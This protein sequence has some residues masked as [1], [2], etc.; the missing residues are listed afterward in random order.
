MG[1]RTMKQP[2][3]WGNPSDSPAE[4]QR[5]RVP[6]SY[7]SQQARDPF[8]V[9]GPAVVSFSGGRT[10]AMMLRLIL[11]RE[12]GRLPADVHAVFSNTGRERP[13]TLDF[14][15]DCAE[16]WG[17][18]VTW[19]ERAPG[20]HGDLPYDQRFRI[21]DHA[22]ASRNGEP[23]AQLIKQRSFPPSRVMRFCTTELKIRVMR[24]FMRSRGYDY[25]TNIVGLRADETKRVVNAKAHSDRERWAI[26]CPLHTA[27]LTVHD[28]AAFW[29]AQP[30]DLRLKSYEGNCDLCFLKGRRKRER[31][32]RD[33]PDLAEWWIEQE[34]AVGGRFHAHEPGYELSLIHI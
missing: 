11:D 10:S 8:R 33:R 4:P 31:I 25:W 1:H 24:D 9:D 26:D 29:K 19:L 32:M 22:T 16:R 3:L 27:G 6:E 18:A 34:R 28:V 23:F 20:P 7:S 17:V 12:D 14:V 13:E 5:G 30:F 2:D 15:R 21:V